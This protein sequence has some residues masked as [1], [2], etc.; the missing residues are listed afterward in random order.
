MILAV[1]GSVSF[2]ALAFVSPVL[3]AWVNGDTYRTNGPPHE[4]KPPHQVTVFPNW[5]MLMLPRVY[6]PMLVS[7]AEWNGMEVVYRGYSYGGEPFIQ[8][9]EA[10]YVLPTE[11]PVDP[12]P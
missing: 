10:D 2:L 3:L 6:D 7:F 12:V 11:N 4:T 8:F 9:L 1:V 5:P